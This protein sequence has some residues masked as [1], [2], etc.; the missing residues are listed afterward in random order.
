VRVLLSSPGLVGHIHPLVP[1]AT[2]LRT[3]G[4]DVRWAAG[5][6]GCERVQ[7]AGF[8]ALAAGLSQE[9]RFAQFL[10]GHP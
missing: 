3:R 5:P 2:A 9:E 7:R 4:H 1:L 6:D 8:E 10:S